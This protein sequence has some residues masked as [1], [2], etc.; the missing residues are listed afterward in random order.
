VTIH[1]HHEKMI[2]LLGDMQHSVVA[3]E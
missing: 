1:Y 2:E 3:P